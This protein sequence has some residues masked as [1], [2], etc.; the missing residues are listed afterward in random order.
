MMM[1]PKQTYT[2]KMAMTLQPPVSTDAGCI[3]VGEVEKVRASYHQTRLTM[4]TMPP[5]TLALL[6]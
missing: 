5:H 6:L 1:E 2:V 4:V 3:V